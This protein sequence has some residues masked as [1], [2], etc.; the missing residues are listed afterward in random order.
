VSGWFLLP[1]LLLRDYRTALV[2]GD[3]SLPPRMTWD[4]P[5]LPASFFGRIRA[6]SY[7]R[8]MPPVPPVK[9]GAKLAG[10]FKLFFPFAGSP[11]AQ[12]RTGQVFLH[13]LL[14]GAFNMCDFGARDDSVKPSWMYAGF[15]FTFAPQRFVTHLVQRPLF[16]CFLVI[17]DSPDSFFF[18]PTCEIAEILPRQTGT[19]SS[20]RYGLIVQILAPSSTPGRL[21]T[22]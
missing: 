18:F 17:L 10:R 15:F 16:A 9:Q 22:A 4:D 5:F 20:R 11:L 21:V 8:Y 1:P 6:S 7:S 19:W 3:I 2:P 12:A 14:L 13:A